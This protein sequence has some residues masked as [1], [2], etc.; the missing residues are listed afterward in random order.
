MYFDRLT[1]RTGKP[2]GEVFPDFQ[3]FVY[4]GVNFEPY[5]RKLLE[6]IAR[7]VDTL[8]LFPASEGFFAFQ[9]EPGNPGLL[10]LLN[11]GIF[12]EFV[13]AE[14]FFEPDAPRLTIADVELDKQYAV[15]LTSNAGLWAYSIGD[16]VRFVSLRPHRVVV[17]GRIKHFLSAFGEHVIGEEVEQALRETMAQFS[18]VEVVEFTV[19]PLVSDD[20]ATPSR[21]EWL[22]EFARPPQND[23]AFSAALDTALRRRNSYYDDLRK[24]NIL[25][26]LQ[27]KPLPAGAFQRYMKSLG[28]LGG[29]NKVPRLGNDRK[30]AEGLISNR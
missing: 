23:A 29:Q 14:R 8:E 11:S 21:H 17:T 7:P 15:I 30:V 2:V 6:S 27:L 9:D 10:L 5:R 24:G 19:A 4:G 26:P 28:K 12:F 22:V 3:L 18:E 20:P 16:T 25:V 1:A 13:P